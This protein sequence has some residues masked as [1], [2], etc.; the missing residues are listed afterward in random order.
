MK[1]SRRRGI[2][3]FTALVIAAIMMIWAV[4]ATY[5]ANFQTSATR[6]SYRK[7]E[8][9][10]LAKRATSRALNQLN[11][12]PLWL[13]NHKSSG[14]ADIST[15]GTRCWVE[16]GTGPSAKMVLRCRATLGGTEESM[17]VPI[18]KDS[19]SDTH[20]YS[21]TP[22][23]GGGPDLIAWSTKNKATWESL[24][25]IP[26]VQ[27]ILSTAP[28]PN[29]DV[30]AIG[31]LSQGT[32]LWRYRKGQGWVQMPDPPANV[33]LSSL[34]TGG[35]EQVVCKGSD[36]SL[37]LLPLGSSQ[38]EVMEW[39]SVSP[40]SG[41]VLSNVAANPSGSSVAYATGAGAN[42]QV[43]CQYDKGT[44]SWT[45]YPAPVAQTFD[46]LTGASQGGG[47]PVTDFSGGLVASGTGK[48]FAA[49]NPGTS[50]SVVY[51][52][53]PD[54]PGST[55]GSW[56]AVPPLPALEWQG[57]NVSNPSG[58]ATKV[59]HLQ[60]DEKGGLWAQSTSADGKKFSIIRFP[61]PP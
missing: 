3:L 28:S 51:A 59:E 56:S 43:V 32:G 55:S 54:A 9:Y 45:S 2:I 15:P 24:P 52:F 31:Q 19:D 42:G 41:V 17:S 5:Q 4:A 8:L 35:N 20:V 16:A 30:F 29:G 46:N 37:M 25:P 57:P 26:G 48:L 58:Y 6:H 50:A 39:K 40:P 22:A 27:K 34:S 36:N 11:V 53:K 14:T 12:D 10:Y 60:L 18:L 61:T 44:G 49:S 13:S 23:V 33:S 38:S 7:A 21:I 1:P 47:G